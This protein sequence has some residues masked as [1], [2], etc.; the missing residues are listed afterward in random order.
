MHS[1]IERQKNRVLKSDPIY[2]PAQWTPILRMAKEEGSPY[3]V[4]EVSSSDIMDFELFSQS[5]MFNFTVDS[6]GNK[7]KWNNIKVLHTNSESPNIIFLKT[8]YEQCDY[9]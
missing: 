3:E 4:K 5:A 2:T 8:G 1:N 6:N 7:V 9:E